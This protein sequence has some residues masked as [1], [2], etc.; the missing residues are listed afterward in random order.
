MLNPEC[1]L[2]NDTQL[3]TVICCSCLCLFGHALPLPYCPCR[4]FIAHAY[5]CL[6]A[7][8]FPLLPILDL[9]FIHAMHLACIALLS[10]CL[11]IAFPLHLSS[12]FSFSCFFNFFG[13]VEFPLRTVLLIL[14]VT[15]KDPMQCLTNHSR[16]IFSTFTHILHPISFVPLSILDTY[17]LSTSLLRRNYLFI[18][19]AFSSLSVYL[20]KFAFIHFTKPAPYLIK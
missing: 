15:I 19:V 8:V 11:Y 13:C 17:N 9:L 4:C 6:C 1:I 18:S 2:L 3:I 16:L 20:I 10:Y 14:T 7:H 12:F 5:P